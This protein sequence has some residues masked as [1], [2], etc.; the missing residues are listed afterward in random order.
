MPAS[1]FRIGRLLPRS[2]RA[3]MTLFVLGIYL[4]AGA[5]HGVCDLDLTSTSSKVVVSLVDKSTGHSD[6]ASLADHHCH[7]CFSVFISAPLI[8]AV[9]VTPNAEII[10]ALQMARR[11]LP[12]GIDPPP[13]KSLT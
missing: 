11:G 9:A 3:A 4:V 6:R 2:L 8:A 1:T 10:P 13:P 12:P 5:L 7:G